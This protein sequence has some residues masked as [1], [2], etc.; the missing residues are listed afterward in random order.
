[1]TKIYAPHR[2][3]SG[4]GAGGVVFKDGVAETDDQARL[5][6]FRDAGY[7]IG[8]PR[9]EVERTPTADARDYAEPIMLG[10]PLRDAAV[11]PQPQDFLPP[12]NAGLAD[13]HGPLVVAPEIH[14]SGPAGIRPGEVFVDEPA[15]QERA[16]TALAERVLIQ[17]ETHAEAHADPAVV[18]ALIDPGS[19][20]AR[21]ADGRVAEDTPAKPK[22]S[23]S[24]RPRSSRKAPAKKS[25]G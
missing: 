12:V 10:T 13:P 19:E 5:M 20:E 7:G 24:S 11:N 22:R 14:A 18:P 9:E 2:S 17:R 8:E 4:V 1:M 3:F 25:T 6:Y 21:Q 23:A 16:E 15:R